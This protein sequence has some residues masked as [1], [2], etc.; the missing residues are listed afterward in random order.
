MAWLQSQTWLILISC[1]NL[2]V[3]LQ[4]L[5]LLHIFTSVTLGWNL[6]T[7]GSIG[8]I[9]ILPAIAP[10][11]T[12]VH[13]D[14]PRSETQK[15]C[16]HQPHWLSHRSRW[17]QQPQRSPQS[18]CPWPTW[19]TRRIKIL[20]WSATDLSTS[21]PQYPIYRTKKYLP[22]GYGW[23]MHQGKSQERLKAFQIFQIFWNNCGTAIQQMHVLISLIAL[24]KHLMPKLSG[25]LL[26][27]NWDCPACAGKKGLVEDIKHAKLCSL[28][29]SQD[30]QIT[31][32]CHGCYVL[33][34]NVDMGVPA[35][36]VQCYFG[37][38][39]DKL[40][41]LR[42]VV[43]VMHYLVQNCCLPKQNEIYKINK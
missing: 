35:Q 36:V 12:Q 29:G 16:P 24:P 34:L 4:S 22:R 25:L 11:T 26:D 20:R 33:F 21:W 9:G 10:E 37:C 1:N 6:H 41:G 18:D 27:T 2:L 13:W 28:T 43:I 17:S 23:N 38:V 30:T 7:G 19:L 3:P 8:S 31:G 14:W 42:P 5:H 15:T 32:K 40:H 39:G